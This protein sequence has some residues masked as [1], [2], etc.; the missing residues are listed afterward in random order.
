MSEVSYSACEFHR[1][2]K[3]WVASSSP[4]RRLNAKRMQARR[5]R[6]RRGLKRRRKEYW[7]RLQRR[8]ERALIFA[9]HNHLRQLSECGTKKEV[10]T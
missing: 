3:S 4:A 8:L 1:R 7:G 10:E 2:Y 5:N 6:A 9:Y